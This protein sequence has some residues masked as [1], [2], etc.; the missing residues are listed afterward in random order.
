MKAL[1]SRW[2][3]LA[4]GGIGLMA[5]AGL[6][7]GA[8]G[9]S[10]S[11]SGGPSGAT[12]A[13]PPANPGSPQT[14]T[15]TE[16]HN[17]ALHKLYLGDTDRTGTPSSSAWMNYGFN[18]DGKCS[19][20]ASTDVCTPQPGGPAKVHDNGNNCID[21]SFGHLILPIITSV[22]SN[23][24][25]TINDSINTGSFTVMFDT[26]GLADA[27]LMTQTAVGLNG[28]LLA[29]SKFSATGQPTWTPADNW[30]VNPSLLQ[31]GTSDPRNSLVKFPS[32]YVVNGTFVAG[33]P[34]QIT[35]SLSIGSVE[36]DLTVHQA[37][38]VFNH[39][40]K[41][42]AHNGTIAGV[43]NTTELIAALQK[44]AGRIATSLC[45]GSEFQSIAAQISGASDVVLDPSSG[46]VTNAAGVE[47]NAIS[48]GLGFDADEIGLPQTIAPPP[49]PTPDPCAATDGGAGG[50]G[51]GG[52]GGTGG[53]GGGG[54]GGGGGGGAGGGGGGDDGGGDAAGDAAGE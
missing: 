4:F 49:A 39:N 7:G 43:I 30:P 20:A 12:G 3:W 24:S 15:P 54:T 14:T 33:Q 47:C 17:F 16:E 50:G 28:N 26:F 45:S 41:G 9:C 8:Q 1:G 27:L 37:I 40:A 44:V 46:A 48:I 2:Q 34:T 25:T 21:N 53:G 11:S 19:T 51:G 52:G 5:G 13:Q 10:S 23:A 29:G 35:L 32:A 31:P 36:I 18:L 42:Q 22:S 38:I 6:I